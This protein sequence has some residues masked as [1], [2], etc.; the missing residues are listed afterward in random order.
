MLFENEENKCYVANLVTDDDSSVRKILTH[1]YRKQL[2]AS[3]ITDADWPRYANG[4][5]KPDNGLLSLL[6]AIIRF[7]ADKGYRVRGYSRF[8]FAEAIKSIANGCGCTKVDAERIKRRLSWT[9]RLHCLFGIYEQFQTAVLAVLEHHF[10]NHQFCGNWCKSTS[11]TAEEVSAA[12][13]RFRCKERNKELYLV[14]KK[15][16]E[17]FMEESKLRQLFHSYDTNT[18]EG[19]NKFLTKFLLK[20]RTGPTAKQSK[21]RLGQC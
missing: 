3:V 17:E 20:D 11:G 5:K 18:V 13:L 16:H 12:G 1:S 19:F 15:H 6:H 9:L 21:I 4:K 2:A 8:L 7:L 14:L 10:N